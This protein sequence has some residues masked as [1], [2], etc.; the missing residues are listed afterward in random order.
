M[1]RDVSRSGEVV[2]ASSFLS[3]VLRGVSMNELTRRLGGN[4]E[5]LFAAVVEF[6]VTAALR[7]PE[8]LE[9]SD[10]PLDPCRTRRAIEVAARA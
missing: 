5:G 10:L 1:R 3:T 2:V 4:K 8:D 9:V 7:P 6:L